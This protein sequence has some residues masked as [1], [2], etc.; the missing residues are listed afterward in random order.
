M[1]VLNFSLRV[2][3]ARA[4]GACARLDEGLIEARGSSIG[5]WRVPPNPL[6]TASLCSGLGGKGECFV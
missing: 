6:G 3:C 2:A 1:G 5:H 4:L